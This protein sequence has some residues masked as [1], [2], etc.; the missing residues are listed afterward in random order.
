MGTAVVAHGYTSPVLDAAEHDLDFVPL[1]VKLLIVTT[2]F[3]PVLSG[4]NTGRDA[5]SE[6]SGTEPVGII[7]TIGN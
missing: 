5:F 3:L 6:Q 2:F 7:A 1:F 4:R